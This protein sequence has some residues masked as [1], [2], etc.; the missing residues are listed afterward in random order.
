ML[1]VDGHQLL[2]DAG[3][4]PKRE[5]LSSLPLYETVKDLEVDA[6]EDFPISEAE[7]D[8]LEGDEWGRADA[9]GGWGGVLHGDHSGMATRM[10]LKR[11]SQ[12]MTLVIATTTLDVVAPPTPAAPPRTVSP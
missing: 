4:H 10:M 2:M 6:A 8:I 9:C 7:V 1:S 5:G 12:A 11:L 3:T